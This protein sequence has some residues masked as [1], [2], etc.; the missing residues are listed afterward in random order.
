MNT[1]ATFIETHKRPAAAPELPAPLA[2]LAG[3]IAEAVTPDLAKVAERE[4]ASLCRP[5]EAARKRAIEERLRTDR[6]FLSEFRSAVAQHA[7]KHGLSE[8]DAA[9]LVLDAYAKEA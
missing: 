2:S 1:Y 6:T 8:T 5:S 9:P 3:R 7:A 4:V